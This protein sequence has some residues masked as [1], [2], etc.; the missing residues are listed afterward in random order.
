MTQEK[1]KL[2]LAGIVNIAIVAA[3]LLLLVAGATIFNRY[4]SSQ[5]YQESIN[6]LTEIS[7]QLFEKLEVQLNIQWSYLEKM[8]DRQKDSPEMSVDELADFL[9][10]REE[11]LSPVGETLQFI[12]VDAYD[13]YYTEQGKQ[14]I[15]TGADSLDDSQAQQSFLVTD[16]VTNANMMVFARRLV[17]PL[18]VDNAEIKYFAVLK[19][20]DAMAPY[21]RSSAFHNQNTTYVLDSNGVKMFSD[22]VTENLNFSGR[23]IY[24]TMRTQSYPHMGSFDACLDAIAEDTFVCTDVNIDGEDYYLALKQLEGYNWSMMFFVPSD[25]VAVSTRNMTSSMVRVFIIVLSVLL[26]LS[27]LS[28]LFVTR[29]RKNQEL[30][31]IKTKSEAELAE[32]NKK[33]EAANTQLET[34]NDQLA[35]AN[36]RLESTNDQL[37]ASNHKLEQAQTAAKEALAVAE[38]A[39]RAKTD[40]LSNMSHDIRTPMNAI[41]GITTLMENELDD[42]EKMR[43][44]LG[45]LKTSSQHLLGIINDILDMNKIESGKAALHNE[46]MSIA[47]QIAQVD[48]IIRPQAM[49]RGQQFSVVTTHLQHENVLGDATRLNQVLINI[50]SNSVKYTPN[51][52]HILFEIEEIPRN[53]HY[54]RYKFIVQDDGIGMS[55]EFI[56]HIYDPFTRAENSTVNKVQGAGLGMAITKSVVELMGGIIH[57]DSALDKGSRFEVTLEFAIDAKADEGVRKMSLLLMHCDAVNYGR[58]Y[59]AVKGKPITLFSA[60]TLAEGTAALQAA[61][62][63]AVLLPYSLADL[64]GEADA[65]R[66]QTNSDTVFLGVASS[67]ENPEH[68][69]ESGLDGYLPLPFFLSNLESEVSRIQEN[70]KVAHAQA[71]NS[72]LNGMKFLCAEDNAINA[73]I[74][75]ML[76][77]TKGASCTIYSNGQQIVDAFAS[78]KPGDY[79]MILMDVQMPVMSGLDATRAIRRSSNPLGKTIPILA[80]TANAF[81]EDVQKS[82]DAGMD[83]HLSKPVDLKMLE[84]TVRRFRVTPPRR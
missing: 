81:T 72:P 10:G 23:N 39:S 78:V 63:D 7:S 18:T 14:G 44:H 50:L 30:L 77:E 60:Q 36:D 84:Q 67:H 17:S 34:T 76:L 58:I 62:Y 75:E 47:D 19:S 66:T 22:S 31:A 56:Q 27:L 26:G 80:M 70:R 57:I 25:E 51:G 65:L 1:K 8:D 24:H 55:K 43:I 3:L 83:A 21:F 15:W 42:P 54:A 82:L 12:A 59:D 33:L 40:F 9:R 6:Q 4:T 38:T 32:A 5:L 48:S 61:P 74:L 35:A 69:T 52:G 53:G 64:K 29:F 45:K 79:D 2:S 68:L 13:Y 71:D 11:E 49:E 37:E 41:I 73:E 16:W 28:F 20:M 46:S